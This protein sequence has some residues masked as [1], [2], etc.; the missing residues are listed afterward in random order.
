MSDIETGQ[1]A[2][3]VEVTSE[4]RFYIWL[5]PLLGLMWVVSCVGLL[6]LGGLCNIIGVTPLLA[7]VGV[8]IVF[9]DRCRTCRVAELTDE[10]LTL[11]PLRR[12][13]LG[14]SPFHFGWGEVKEM[15]RPT[16]LGVEKGPVRVTLD[17]PHPFWTLKFPAKR[18]VWV[19]DDIARSPQF[20]ELARKHVPAEN[21]R[22]GSLSVDPGKERR[23]RLLAGAAAGIAALVIAWCA[24]RLGL[25]IGGFWPPVFL[26]WFVAIGAG[27]FA[28]GALQEPAP[29]WA[30]GFLWGTA[31]AVVFLITP[32]LLIAFVSGNADILVASMGAAAG[33]LLAGA[34]PLLRGRPLLPSGAVLCYALA[35]IG[36]VVG[37]LGYGGIPSTRVSSGT[38]PYITAPWTPRGD[39]FVVLQ[40]TPD[41]SDNA[42][43]TP[44]TV[45]WYSADLTPGHQMALP[46]YPYVRCVGADAALVMTGPSKPERN[47]ELWWLPRRSGEARCLLAA[48]RLD[49]FAMD[50]PG[51]TAIIRVENGGRQEWQRC[52]LARG[53]IAPA[54]L[55]ILPDEVEGMW[56]S[57]KGTLRWLVGRIPRDRKGRGI[58][59][60]TGGARPPPFAKPGQRFEIWERREG[61]D[62]EPKMLYQAKTEWLEYRTR[63]GAPPISACRIKAGSRTRVE[64]IQV[65]VST[66]VPVV[67]EISRQRYERR[68]WPNAEWDLT[69]THQSGPLMTFA[70]FARVAAINRA[71]GARK[72]LRGLVGFSQP[73][74]A[75]WS[76]TSKSFLY[77]AHTLK[78][79]PRW[80]GGPEPGLVFVEEVHIVDLPDH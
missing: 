53:E 58:S 2:P 5:V 31:N 8:F 33:F 17:R 10:G 52:D 62:L 42:E 80:Q 22:A 48:D 25:G 13:R 73:P 39:A 49:F 11:R 55:P 44:T 15:K 59:L 74:D 24:V 47:R 45:R 65:D 28:R 69:A 7:G 38:L 9:I 57:D 77:S 1:K 43:P 36:G 78:L 41:S 46:G 34:F 79:Q 66:G 3:P 61:D 30:L 68:R 21:I 14:A 29:R 35:L 56:F 71:T 40:P 72:M 4:P 60:G 20:V 50:L 16:L 19:P 12:S 37:Y 67:S 54:D 32:V 63:Y 51:K 18:R 26:V 70:P 76:P 27:A 64:Y 6:V 75:F 23:L